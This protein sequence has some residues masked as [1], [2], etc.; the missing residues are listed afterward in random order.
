VDALAPIPRA[1]RPAVAPRRLLRLRSD[2]A[3]GERFAAGDESAF[4]VL[5]DRHW[6]SVLAVCIVVLGSRHDAEDAAQ[7]AFAALV[8]ALSSDPPRDLRA[9]LVRVGRNA[10]IDLA[11][12][13]QR[14]HQGAT[15]IETVPQ[16]A[17]D[18]IGAELDSVLAGVRQLPESQR[19]ALLM[20]ELA[21]HSYDEIA[22]M[23]NTH[24]D[25]VRGLIARARV[26]L[27]NYRAAA[28]LP[29]AA[30]QAALATEPDGRRHERT[31]RRHVRGCGPCQAYREA[32][33]SDARALRALAP[34]PV[35]GVAG[36]GAMV[37]LAAKG[38]L[39]GGGAL[40]VGQLGAACAASLGCVG[41]VV[42]LAPH[43]IAHHPARVTRDADHRS[44]IRAGAHRRAPAG[45]AS[46]AAASAASAA[47]GGSRLGSTT[48]P[49]V[50]TGSGAPAGHAYAAAPHIRR[51]AR[52]D[53]SSHIFSWRSARA[54]RVD[55]TRQASA[56][57]PAPGG[58]TRGGGAGDGSSAGSPARGRGRSS[59]GEGRS[60]GPG[61]AVPGLGATSSVT[62]DG[63]QPGAG[64]ST[65]DGA[66][67]GG[68]AGGDQPGSSGS[69]SGHGG[70][71]GSGSDGAPA[72][73][74]DG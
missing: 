35:A 25:A 34:P 17:G 70:G 61:G 7:E 21:G 18:G 1:P 36:S 64:G 38:A 45:P 74:S 3:L 54:G 67:P 44:A 15:D 66:G 71:T 22:T 27:R 58:G 32:L 16:P 9:W 49:A 23:L 5:Y 65:S 47:S 63:A 50:V 30:A 10:A 31:V 57:E 68:N 40:G 52:A 56:D 24:Q 6:R 73:G 2:A 14:M 43:P 69:G 59:A 29:C 62:V 20:R 4:A 60:G 13:R 53:R 41:A 37:G 51:P 33:R 12:R 55:G 72:T 28:E 42:M 48:S 39:A 26:S 11:R 46:G 19:T 8:V